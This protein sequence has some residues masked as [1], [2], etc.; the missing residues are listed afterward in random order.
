MVKNI[1]LK[2]PCYKCEDRET[3]CHA[4]CPRGIAYETW[5]AQEKQRVR[6]VRKKDREAEGYKVDSI[7]MQ[8]GEM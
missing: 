6:D 5:W 8:K 2:N 4:K 7:R 1:K 3:G